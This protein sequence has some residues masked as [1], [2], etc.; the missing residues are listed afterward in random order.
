[1]IELIVI[2]RAIG[3]ATIDLVSIAEAATRPDHFGGTVMRSRDDIG[4][5]TS[6]D[7]QEAE[8]EIFASLSR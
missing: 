7:R 2:P 8:I 3:I 6:T 1:M 5:A 4:L